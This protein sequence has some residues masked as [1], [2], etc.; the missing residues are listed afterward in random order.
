MMTIDRID[1]LLLDRTKRVAKWVLETFGISNYFVARVGLSMCL[2]AEVSQIIN[3]FS[4]FLPD[5]TDALVC[6]LAPGMI[7]I[8]TAQF[9]ACVRAENNSHFGGRVMEMW[10]EYKSAYRVLF[11][12]FAV[13]GIG[14]GLLTGKSMQLGG[15]LQWNSFEVGQVIFLYFVAIGPLPPV[16]SKLRKLIGSFTAKPAMADAS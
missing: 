5:R 16:V 3:R 4:R 11:A 15:L 14:S 10:L 2:L 13:F 9:R 12:S 7:G 8:I 6:F 1:D